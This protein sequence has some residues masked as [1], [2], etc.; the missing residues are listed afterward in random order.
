MS[1]IRTT[2]PSAVSGPS[3]RQPTQFSP[4]PLLCRKTRAAGHRCQI[5][6]HHRA[7]ERMP[8][9]RNSHCAPKDRKPVSPDGKPMFLTI[10]PTAVKVHID[11]ALHLVRSDL[12]HSPLSQ[13]L[14]YSADGNPAQALRVLVEAGGCH[15]F[16]YKLDLVDSKQIAQ[17]DVL[18]DND[19]AKLVIDE[20]SLELVNGSK[21]VFA[22]ELIGQEFRLV[23]NPNAGSSCGCGTSFEVKF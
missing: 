12:Y 18:F 4:S 7:M 8:L 3:A 10:D 20:T 19:G 13:T 21:L 11:A 16:Q 2:S 23:D 14:I 1:I 22:D 17:D 15:G 6:V 9:L 5:A